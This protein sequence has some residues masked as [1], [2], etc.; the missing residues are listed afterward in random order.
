MQT[1]HENKSDLRDHRWHQT[2]ASSFLGS[3][4]LIK[5]RT[6]SSEK[7]LRAGFQCSTTVRRSEIEQRLWPATARQSAVITWEMECLFRQ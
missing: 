6:C 1:N 4:C 5:M 7:H 3:C 2:T